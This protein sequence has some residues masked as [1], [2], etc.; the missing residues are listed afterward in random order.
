[1]P[2]S[3]AGA[4]RAD[5]EAIRPGGCE[6]YA[7]PNCSVV[8]IRLLDGP[9]RGRRSFIT[10]NDDRFTPDVEAGDRVRVTRS[11]ADA[12]GPEPSGGA[13]LERPETQ[14]YAFVDFERRTP[15]AVLALIFGALLVVLGR[16]QGVRALAG[17]GVSLVVVVLF[18]AP[19]IL[20]GR[21][22]L[23]VAVIGG[24]AVMAATMGLTHGIGLKSQAALLGT[25]LALIL[26]A[27][28]GTVA[29]DAA[30]ITGLSEETSLLLSASS[31]RAV[32]LQGLV[33][34]G[35]VI[36][37][38]GVLDDITVSQASTVLALRRVNPE[39]GAR[40][41]YDEALG[42]GRDH[43]GAT[44]NTLVLAYAGA[45]LPVLLIFS[46]QGVGFD[47]AVNFES[48]AAEVVATLVGSIGLIA[49][50]PLTTAL[51]A[52]L[53]VRLPAAALPAGDG[54]GHAH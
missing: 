1:P 27:V 36:G 2:S 48:V 50:V 44:V 17:L 9:N 12:S 10:L 20:E 38:L 40:R 51:A 43:L 46:Y 24:L 30:Q 39:L 18:V 5:V 54:H 25:A 4:V 47:G 29:V 31:G 23:L 21:A 34:A 22:P 41:L 52:T 13:D 7:G 33:L 32:S 49:A 14:P 45:A 8:A 42:V 3:L 26:I 19:A 11:R 6:A 35:L 16:W 28:L 53:A 15:L 37:A